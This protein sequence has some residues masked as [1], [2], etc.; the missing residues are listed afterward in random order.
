MELQLRTLTIGK[1]PPCRCELGK[2]WNA[3]GSGM[4][5]LTSTDPSQEN[6][7]S[8]LQIYH[9]F[10]LLLVVDKNQIYPKWWCTMLESDKK[11]QQKYIRNPWKK[12]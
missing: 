7:Q 5:L 2:C 6:N 4:N 11:H 9:T 3:L 1:R 12:H 10:D 8:Y